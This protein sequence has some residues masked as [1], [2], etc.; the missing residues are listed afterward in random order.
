MST[1]ASKY[2]PTA[3]DPP[4]TAADRIRAYIRATA[5][6]LAPPLRPPVLALSDE[7]LT[8]LFSPRQREVL[9]RGPL[10]RPD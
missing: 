3:V 1:L 2:G 6:A 9:I 4:E 10:G 7:Q 5:A 8:G